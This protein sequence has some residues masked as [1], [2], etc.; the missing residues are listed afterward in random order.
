[1]L[2]VDNDSKQSVVGFDWSMIVGSRQT[3]GSDL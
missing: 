1:M 3:Q 2:F